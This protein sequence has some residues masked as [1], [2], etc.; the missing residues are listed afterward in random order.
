[1]FF[2]YISVVRFSSSIPW[3]SRVDKMM[4]WI[5]DDEKPAN[6]VFAYFEEPDN[7]G[8]VFGIGSQEI[9][10]QIVRVDATVKYYLLFLNHI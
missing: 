1:M 3:T 7:T 9:K 8:H 2:F 10:N 5:K 6:L 4:S